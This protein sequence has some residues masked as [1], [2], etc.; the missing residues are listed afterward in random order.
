MIAAAWC[1]LAGMVPPAAV[2]ASKAESQR[3]LAEV[4]A[5]IQAVQTRLQKDR[6]QQ[7]QLRIELED[8]EK[9]L[10][11]AQ[12]RL[13]ELRDQAADQQRKVA[14]TRTLQEQAAAE[15]ERQRRALGGQLRAAFAIGRSG[16][17]K[18]ILNQEQVHRMGL[19]LD[20]YEYL[21]RARG[22]RIRGVGA[23]IEMMS[24]IGRRLTTEL[25]ALAGLRDEQERALD[26][27]QRARAERARTVERLAERIADAEAELGRLTA[28]ERRLQNLLQQLAEALADLP[29]TDDRPLAQLQ[30]KLP[31][32]LR[33]KLL[34]RF[35]ET[36][37]GGKFTWRGLWIEAPEGA[38]VKAVAAGRIAYVG[39]MQRYGL[40]AIVE[41]PGG[42]YTLYGHLQRVSRSEGQSIKGGETLAQA[43]NTGG[44][45]R[46]G[47]YFE[48][49]KGRDP[50]DPSA[51]L[52]R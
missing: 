8:V 13:R 36:K 2:A 45:D 52:G 28:N 16:P 42:Y 25:E 30:G 20:Y 4:K 38:A 15:I 51:W 23:Q 26:E 7:D 3:Q 47:L 18:L 17:L 1:L 6:G 50:V 44:Y 29:V 48:I 35:G 46:T 31:W 27:L 39:W 41:H 43:G 11:Q 21:N 12:Q 37:S 22:E 5:R 9:K 40:I 14:D 34:A 10:A 24:D 19:V 32:P 33:G 49:R